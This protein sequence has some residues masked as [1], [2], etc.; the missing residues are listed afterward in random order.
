MLPV[1]WC[2]DDETP[3]Y[4]IAIKGLPRGR[5]GRESSS[6][7]SLEEFGALLKGHNGKNR[8]GKNAEQRIDPISF[9]FKLQ[10]EKDKTKNTRL[11]I[12]LIEIGKLLFCF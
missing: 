9:G 11:Q 6:T 2:R 4:G 12:I 5:K 3:E 1:C 10:V 8:R 7:G